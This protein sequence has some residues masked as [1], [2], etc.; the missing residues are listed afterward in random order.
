MNLSNIDIYDFILCNIWDISCV[1]KCRKIIC[2]RK[3]SCVIKAHWKLT[4][5]SFE[6]NKKTFQI[7]INNFENKL[8]IIIK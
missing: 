3:I 2:Y 1:E 6:R 7:T 5:P 4:Q 8:C